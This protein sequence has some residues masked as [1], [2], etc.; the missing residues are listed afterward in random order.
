[1]SALPRERRVSTRDEI[2]GLLRGHVVRGADLELYW[3]PAAGEASRATC[4]TPKYGHTSVQR[5]RLR[6]RVTTLLASELLN[7][8]EPRDYVVRAR[9]GAYELDFQGL[10]EALRALAEEMT[11]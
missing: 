6:R 3:R 2:L 1:M 10:A 4:I 5:N 11:A 8:P 9:A 7:R